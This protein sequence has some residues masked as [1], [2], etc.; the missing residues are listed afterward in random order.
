[1]MTGVTSFTFTQDTP[2][3]TWVITHNFGRLVNVDAR[4]QIDGVLNKVLPMKIV[5]TDL[6][7]V[8]VYWSAARA[9]SALVT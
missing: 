3:D 5:A 1:M 9:G 2:S 7:T 4:L 6:N 8:T